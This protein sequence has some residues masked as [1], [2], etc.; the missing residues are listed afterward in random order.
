[1]EFKDRFK[2]LREF[3]KYGTQESFAAYLGFEKQ[4]VQKYE[5]GNTKPGMDFLVILFEKTKVNLNWLLTGKGEMFS[6]TEKSKSELVKE[7]AELKRD[8]Q[9]VNDAIIS[10]VTDLKKIINVTD[11]SKKLK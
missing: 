2:R 4:Y 10:Q 8:R 5:S 7:I 9:K 6:E 11:Q 3:L 1:M